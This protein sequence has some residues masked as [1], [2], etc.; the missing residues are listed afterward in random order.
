MRPSAILWDLD[1]TLCD[2]AAAILDAFEHACRERGRNVPP[3]EAVVSR[4]GMPLRLM[5]RDLLGVEDRESAALVTSYRARFEREAPRLVRAAPGAMDAIA[6]FP[7][8]PMAVVTTKATEPARTVLKALGLDARIATVVGVDT[9]RRPKPDPE[10]VR[11]A[12]ARL[13]V[14]AL[15]SVFVGDT[16]MDVLAGKGAAVRTVAVENGHGD[17]S[18]LKAAQ[19]DAL[20]PDLTH[21]ARV[22][23]SL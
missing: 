4:I 18:E 9:V 8:V 23:S 7:K 13:Q 6:A 12:L 17:P 22:I 11:V 3:R 15:E 14:G 20:I 5:F 10:G 2:G 21:L 1:G 19:P 16:V